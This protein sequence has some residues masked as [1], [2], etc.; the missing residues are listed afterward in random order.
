MEPGM[1]EASYSCQK[2][3][4]ANGCTRYSLPQTSPIPLSS[5]I[6]PSQRVFLYF[7]KVGWQTLVDFH[8]NLHRGGTEF[9]LLVRQKDGLMTLVSTYLKGQGTR[10]DAAA[11]HHRRLR[12]K[13]L[14]KCSK[15]NQFTMSGDFLWEHLRCSKKKNKKKHTLHFLRQE[16]IFF[17]SFSL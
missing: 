5:H 16:T 13:L 4:H 9:S 3:I 8:S 10:T 7:S 1:G 15:E 14:G 11:S 6:W 2:K 12:A 17:P